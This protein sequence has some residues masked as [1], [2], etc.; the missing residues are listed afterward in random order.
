M[1]DIKDKDECTDDCC[2]VKISKTLSGK[3]LTNL[4]IG[5]GIGASFTSLIMLLANPF[6]LGLGVGAALGVYA[7]KKG[8]H[9]GFFGDCGCC[10]CDC[11]CDCE[12]DCDCDECK[13]DVE[14]EPDEPDEITVVAEED[15]A[16]AEEAAEP[17]VE[18][19]EVDE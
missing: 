17:P 5:I 3:D 4:G 11:D 1:A 16:V 10:D 13:I 2:E 8:K 15:G 19:T 12:D 14:I 7:S 9:L 6:T 18:N